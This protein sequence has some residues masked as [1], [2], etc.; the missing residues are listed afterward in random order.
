[1][2]KKL[3]YYIFRLSMVK[4]QLWKKFELNKHSRKKVVVPPLFS[5]L[6]TGYPNYEYVKRQKMG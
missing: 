4:K 6:G 1:M 3:C 5:G 2:E